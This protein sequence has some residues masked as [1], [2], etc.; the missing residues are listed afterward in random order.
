MARYPLF[1]IIQRD[2]L[3][4]FLWIRE[5]RDEIARKPAQVTAILSV[6]DEITIESAQNK[7]KQL[8]LKLNSGDLQ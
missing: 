6:P 4:Y 2:H 1:A 3:G 8:N 5:S 7:V